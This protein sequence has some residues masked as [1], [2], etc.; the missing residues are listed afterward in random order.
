[1]TFYPIALKYSF[2]MCLLHPTV[3]TLRTEERYPFKQSFNNRHMTSFMGWALYWPCR[4]NDD[5]DTIYINQG[6]FLQTTAS[7][8]TSLNRK[9]FITEN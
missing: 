8:L 3:S 5:L 4:H 2:H 1:M 6:A 7:I 9:N